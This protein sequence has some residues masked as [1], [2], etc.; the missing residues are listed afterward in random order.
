MFDLEKH[1]FSRSIVLLFPFIEASVRKWV[2]TPTVRFNSNTDIPGED[3]WRW[4]RQ[5][6]MV[7]PGMTHQILWTLGF[8]SR[9]WVYRS[10]LQYSHSRWQHYR[11]LLDLPPTSVG[12]ALPLT[13][14]RGSHSLELDLLLFGVETLSLVCLILSLL[15]HPAV[16]PWVGGC[17]FHKPGIE[18]RKTPCS[19]Q[20]DLG[21]SPGWLAHHLSHDSSGSSPKILSIEH[22]MSGFF[23]LGG[24]SH[25]DP[26]EENSWA[27]C[28]PL[29]HSTYLAGHSVWSLLQNLACYH[30]WIPTKGKVFARTFLLLTCWNPPTRHRGHHPR[31]HPGSLFHRF[32][33]PKEDIFLSFYNDE[34]LV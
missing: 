29:P 18:W 2:I 30:C 11:N 32:S 6:Q 10:L 19:G 17:D 24:G 20:Q 21:S 26:T 14:D 22:R 4:P 31:R 9:I 33:V 23:G 5:W 34:S 13:G 25:W 7:P 12:E 8:P 3:W 27:Q 1:R 16:E 28:S 15:P